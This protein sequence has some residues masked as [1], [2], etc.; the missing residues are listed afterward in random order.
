M[1]SETIDNWVLF[2]ITGKQDLPELEFL[3]NYTLESF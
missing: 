2:F 1:L 3:S